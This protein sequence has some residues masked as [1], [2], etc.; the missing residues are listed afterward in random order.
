MSF[1]S[2]GVIFTE[3]LNYEKNAAILANA[4]ERALGSVIAQVYSSNVMGYS[5]FSKLYEA[6]ITPI[7]DYSAA[8]W[9]FSQY[10][11]IGVYPAIHKFAP[12]RFYH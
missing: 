5:T 10:R 9:A 6:C 3:H 4:G 12:L 8:V 2:F 11:A 7:L 1:M